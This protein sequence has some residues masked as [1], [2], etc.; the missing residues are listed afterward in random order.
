MVPP[1]HHWLLPQARI[2][3]WQHNEL[4]REAKLTCVLPPGG[5]PTSLWRQF[6][7][8]TIDSMDPTNLNRPLLSKV[9]G[10]GQADLLDCL[11]PPDTAL[12]ARLQPLLDGNT[13]L[14]EILVKLGIAGYDP[15]DVTRVMAILLDRGLL[16][17]GASDNAAALSEAHAGHHL[18][19]IR[20]FDRWMGEDSAVLGPQTKGHQA[21]VRLAKARVIIIGLG[22]NGAALARSLAGAGIGE[23]FGIRAP[24][25]SGLQ[26]TDSF[27]DLGTAITRANPDT[28]YKEVE[29][30]SD[31]PPSSA[32]V[33]SLMVYCPDDFDHGLCMQLNEVA[34]TSDVPYLI[35]QQT[36]FHV[37]IGPLIFPR[38]TACYICSVLRRKGSHG[39]LNIDET[40]K[41]ASC[42]F[43]FPVGIDFLAV[44]I[45]KLFTQ[46]SL[47]ACRGKIWRLHLTSGVSE[48]HPVLKLPRCV[49]CGSHRKNPSKKLWNI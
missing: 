43:G 18:R 38:Q 26:D 28:V 8:C 48:V 15:R 21:Q 3:T 29:E 46:S 20:L 36:A 4:A 49:A 44:E 27:P 11:A 2:Q 25:D 14:A 9:P 17:E 10:T 16:A 35:Y 42:S 12:F 1:A 6:L 33:A 31:L 47:P 19:Q 39:G 32:E 40:M 45:L 22:R 24:D 37:E 41:G 5:V 30:P 13:D 23:L 7:L 34:L